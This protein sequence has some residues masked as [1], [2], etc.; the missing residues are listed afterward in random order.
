MKYQ[1]YQYVP[2][3]DISEQFVSKLWTILQL[4][5]FLL[6]WMDDNPRMVSRLCIMVALFYSPVRNFFPR[7]S[8]HDLPCHRT[9]K[10]LFLHRVSPWL[11]FLVIFHSSCGNPGFGHTSVIVHNIFANLTFYL[12]ATQINMVEEW[13]WFSQINVFHKDFPSQINVLFLSSQFD[14]IHIHRKE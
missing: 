13:C 9:K 10:I 4:T 11:L 6:L 8:L 14:V 1:V 12:C 7:I 3:T 5:H 2:N